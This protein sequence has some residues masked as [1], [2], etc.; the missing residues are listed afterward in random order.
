MVSGLG[1]WA[2]RLALSVLVYERSQ[3]ALW[4]ALVLAVSLLPWLGPG[5]MLAT[6]ADRLGRVTVMVWCDLVRAA[7]FATLLFPLPLPAVLLVAFAAGMCSPPFNAARSAAMVELT[8]PELYGNA[9]ALYAVVF[10]AEIIVGYGLGGVLIAS[11]GVRAALMVN[12]V[13]FL[14]S[15]L[16]I[17]LLR[18]SRGAERHADAPVGWAGLVAGVDMWRT[19]VF[20]SRAL[21]LFVCVGAVSSL[22]EALVVP[23]VAE[24]GV[25][26]SLMGGLFAA[27][28]L[29]ALVT[30]AMLPTLHSHW[31]LLRSAARRTVTAA[32]ASIGLFLLTW[33]VTTAAMSVWLVSAVAVAAYVVAGAVDV[34]AVQTNQVVGERLPV[35]GRAG[36]MAVGQGA[37]FG[38][39]AAVIGLGGLVAVWAPVPLVLAVAFGGSVCIALWSLAHPLA[40][41]PVSSLAG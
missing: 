9:L 7:L 41:A 31:A 32:I 24:T 8:R 17:G 25:P 5:Q 22:P 6:F 34:V 10:Q 16:L 26:L 27:T 14:A 2:G 18:T 1:D 30:T 29:G 15:A 36:A 33:T 21:L 35:E 37:M 28:A 40:D 19:D 20:R 38:A 4:A 39:Q 3:S 12:V 11:A 23:F 13:S